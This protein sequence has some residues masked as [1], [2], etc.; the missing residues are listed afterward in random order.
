MDNKSKSEK[1]IELKLDWQCQSIDKCIEVIMG[2]LG[3]DRDAAFEYARKRMHVKVEDIP[4]KFTTPTLEEVNAYYINVAWKKIQNWIKANTYFTEV[5]EY[6]FSDDGYFWCKIEIYP[7]GD[8]GIRSGD[9]SSQYE[10]VLIHKNEEFD[11]GSCDN[12]VRWHPRSKSYNKWFENDV[13]AEYRVKR[14]DN[15]FN[16]DYSNT[17]RNYRLIRKLVDNWAFIK[18]EIAQDIEKDKK[19]ASFEA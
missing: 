15:W 3:C 5:K 11:F 6:K 2:L 7:N 9:H 4:T 19:L 16:P 14:T 12:S 17:I 18:N 13:F 8:C 1:K 10:G